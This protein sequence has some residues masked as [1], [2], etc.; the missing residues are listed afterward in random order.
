MEDLTPQ[1]GSVSGPRRAGESIFDVDP[2][3]HE[4]VG[5]SRDYDLG[6]AMRAA[7][8]QLPPQGAGIPD[9]LSTYSVVSIGA[10]IGGIAGFDHLTVRVSG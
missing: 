10:E 6:E 5:R 9:W 2:G 7:I 8:A 3:P 4:A 1:L